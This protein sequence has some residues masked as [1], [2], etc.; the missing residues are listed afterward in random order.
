M[1]K[2]FIFLF[3][4]FLLAGCVSIQ[5]ERQD[6]LTRM[7]DETVLRL[8]E[9]NPGLKQKM[10]SGLGHLVVDIKVVK[11]P[12]LG[13]GSGQGV[14]VENATGK[15]TYVKVSR[16]EIGGGWGARNYKV[17]LTFSDP[18]QMKKAQSG[19]WIY[20][21]GAEASA[22]KASVEGSSQDL[23]EEKGYEAYI[24]SEGG[25]SATYTVRAIRLK[26]YKH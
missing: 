24:L 9:K 22:G 12:V 21:L 14:V 7:A 13:A 19:T 5:P 23:Q 2:Q 6:E 4:V 16:I 3:A 25:A 11:V 26:P 17:L 8:E 1:L 15:R 20:Q 10:E 18:K